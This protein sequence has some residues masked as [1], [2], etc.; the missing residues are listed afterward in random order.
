[1][2]ACASKQ[3]TW[4]RSLSNKMRAYFHENVQWF[5]NNQQKKMLQSC[6]PGLEKLAENESISWRNTKIL[7]FKCA[8]RIICIGGAM[9]NIQRIFSFC[10]TLSWT[11]RPMR[12]PALRL[13]WLLIVS[14][15]LDVFPRQHFSSF[16][17]SSFFFTLF[18]Q[19]NKTRYL[20]ILILDMYF[21]VHRLFFRFKF[22]QLYFFSFVFA[23]T[24]C[25]L[26]NMLWYSITSFH[27]KMHS[28]YSSASCRSIA[29]S[30][31]SC[32]NIWWYGFMC[33]R[34]LS[35]SP[36]VCLCIL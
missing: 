15:C 6:R 23:S 2:C 25:W 12:A 8:K 19:T 5:M 29:G 18:D 21:F 31:I 1:M 22:S 13:S 16:S 27:L 26:W 35:L 20:N 24:C 3:S 33:A 7:A 10:S 30:L 11:W 36:Y 9:Q 34:S 28:S 4:Y 17:V 14:F 32:N